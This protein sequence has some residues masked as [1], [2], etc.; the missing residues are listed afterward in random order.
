MGGSQ[1]EQA[2]PPSMAGV[3][4]LPPTGSTATGWTH[5]S[6]GRVKLPSAAAFGLIQ[7][8]PGWHTGLSL[9]PGHGPWLVAT[10][11]PQCPKP[12]IAGARIVPPVCRGD[13]SE[14]QEETGLSKGKP[15]A[16]C[17]SGYSQAD[18]CPGC[19]TTDQVIWRDE[20]WQ[21]E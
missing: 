6:V 8:G 12:C 4:Q 2:V 20:L 21:H 14:R 3:T 13:I 1:G 11:L 17:G 16:G 18:H 9:Q 19:A 15:L 10:S 7:A 5:P